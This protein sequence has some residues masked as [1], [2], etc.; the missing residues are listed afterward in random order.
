MMSRLKRPKCA[1]ERIIKMRSSGLCLAVKHLNCICYF[2]IIFFK[3]F[4]Y[5]FFHLDLVY[6]FQTKS[7]YSIKV[8]SLKQ[9]TR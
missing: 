5:L 3:F 1:R 4:F 2:T 8:Q 9:G 6:E 7:V